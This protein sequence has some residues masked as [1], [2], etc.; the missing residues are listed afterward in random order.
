MT[1]YKCPV[2]DGMTKR[3]EP[4]GSTEQAG[5]AMACP[6]CSGTGIVWVQLPGTVAITT[7][8]PGWDTYT[9]P[10]WETWIGT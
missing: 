7:S 4:G 8:R 9:P 1:P 5:Q 3:V 2:C 10:E 6:A